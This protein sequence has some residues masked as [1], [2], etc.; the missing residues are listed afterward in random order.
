MHYANGRHA[1]RH[2]A[3]TAAAAAIALNLAA[4]AAVVR[5]AT[6]AAAAVDVALV[7]VGA[8]H[9]QPVRRGR[10]A[11]AAVAAASPQRPLLFVKRAAALAPAAEAPA[12]VATV[13]RA[14]AL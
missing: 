6:A 13:A 7:K 5:I 9:R 3:V 11:H 1:S 14:V 10:T 8:L 2:R 4:A 12:G